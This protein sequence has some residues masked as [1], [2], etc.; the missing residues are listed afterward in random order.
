MKIT[1][2]VFFLTVLTVN[3]WAQTTLPGQ[4]AGAWRGEGTIFG[5]ASSSEMRWEPILGGKFVTL[6]WR[7]T[8]QGRDGKPQVFEGFG[9]Y[10]SLGDGKCEGWWFDSRGVSFPIAATFDGKLLTS[11]WGSADTESGRTTYRLVE[12]NLIEV[13]D[14]VRSK[15][16]SWKEF[17]RATLKRTSV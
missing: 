17:A 10:K 6:T 9:V 15:D 4:L 7:N 14:F 1:L 2:E 11:Q 5:A 3:A 16:G 13:I 12:D 8:W